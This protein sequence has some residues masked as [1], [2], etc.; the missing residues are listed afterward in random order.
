VQKLL[1]GVGAFIALL[2]V[3]GF[4]LPRTHRTEASIEIDAHPATV[5]ALLNDFPE[6]TNSLF[7]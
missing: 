7:G 4:A 6:R 2:I 5:F 1:Y 3:I